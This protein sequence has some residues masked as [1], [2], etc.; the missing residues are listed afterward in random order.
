MTKPKSFVRILTIFANS[1][2]TRPLE[3]YM[4]VY[5]AQTGM[6]DDGVPGFFMFSVR[7]DRVLKRRYAKEET[8]LDEMDRRNKAHRRRLGIKT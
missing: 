7:L 8:A 1:T 3:H 5:Y 6:T 2:T 4:P